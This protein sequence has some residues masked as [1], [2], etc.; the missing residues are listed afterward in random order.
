MAEIKYVTLDEII[1]DVED[2]ESKMQEAPEASISIL[3]TSSHVLSLAKNDNKVRILTDY[4]ADGICS[5]YILDKAL[6]KVNPNIDLEVHCNDRRMSYGVPKYIEAEEDAKYIVL[7]M[8]SNEL[9]YIRNTFGKDTIII[10]HHLINNEA[11]REAFSKDP[12]LLNPHCFHTDDSLN[13]QYCATGLAYRVFECMRGECE[14]QGIE[15]LSEEVLNNTL[16]AM[17]CIGT[18]CDMVNVMD[19]N[20]RNREIIKKGLDIINNAHEENFDF[21]IGHTLS[22]CGINEQDVTAKQIGF[23]VGAFLNSSSRMSAILGENGAMRM[24]N[25]L[26]ANPNNAN[27][28]IELSKLSTLNSERK[29]V[30]AT[31][32]DE[33][34]YE[35]ALRERHSEGNV[36][37]YRLPDNTPTALAGLVA[38]K[39]TDATDK[40]VICVALQE[41]TQ[42]FTG[43]SRNAVGN[44]SLKLFLDNTVGGMNIKYGGHH[45]AVGISGISADDFDLFVE[46]I[47]EN[48]S[49]LKRKEELVLLKM[50]PKEISA[51][52]TLSKMEHLEPLG[53]GLKIPPVEIIGVENEKK[54]DARKANNPNWKDI[55]LK[56]VTKFKA[57]DWGFNDANYP[58]NAKGEIAFLGELEISNFRGKSVECKVRPSRI[59]D[60]HVAELNKEQTQTKEKPKADYGDR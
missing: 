13:A 52:E 40:A 14:K 8:G 15:S 16:G 38:S 41:E 58:T 17:A 27:A 47:N 18:I 39:L 19:M 51:D 28:Y 24:Y 9:D 37:V 43:S 33:T 12:L 44:E 30:V 42:T 5:A 49:N 60:A 34:F 26:T 4:D 55:Q 46:A 59:Y 11:D 45:D 56:G 32:Q 36:F 57:V 23:N 29:A 6:R 1:A 10:D 31:L 48:K 35:T 2:K 20:S 21:I 53:T 22:I 25:A 3:S 7:D 50:S 54:K